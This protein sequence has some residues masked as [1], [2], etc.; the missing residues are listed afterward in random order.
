[1]LT[2]AWKA[3]NVSRIDHDRLTTGT[4]PNPLQIRPIKLITAAY[5]GR[6]PERL[7]SRHAKQNRN[8]DE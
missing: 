8:G 5:G 4:P 2:V 7:Q 1:M 6:C 3:Q